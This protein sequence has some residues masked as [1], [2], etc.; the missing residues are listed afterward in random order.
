MGGLVPGKGGETVEGV[1]VFDT[2]AEAVEILSAASVTV[3]E[4]PAVIGETL[5][6]VMEAA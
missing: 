2:V 4:N 3:A 1:P 5:A 6:R